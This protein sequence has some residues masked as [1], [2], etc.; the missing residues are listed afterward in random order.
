MITGFFPISGP[1]TAAWPASGT[2]IGIEVPR[3][4]PTDRARPVVDFVPPC[5]QPAEASDP[6]TDE[7]SW[8]GRCRPPP[9]AAA[10]GPARPKTE[11]AAEPPLPSQN[12]VR[13]LLH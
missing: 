10:A 13:P 6:P 7:P 12:H 8:T 9:T 11:S 5:G 3:T 4:S 2:R 1:G